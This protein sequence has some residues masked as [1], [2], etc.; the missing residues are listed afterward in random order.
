MK[1]L[2]YLFSFFF[3]ISLTCF[4]LVETNAYEIKEEVSLE[5]HDGI[6]ISHHQGEV[7]WCSLDSSIDF[8]ICKATEGETFIDS[9]FKKNWDSIECVK[10]C[11]HFFRP[12]YS[13]E[14]QALLYLSVINLLPGKYILSIDPESG[15]KVLVELFGEDLFMEW[16]NREHYI[17]FIDLLGD[18]VRDKRFIIDGLSYYI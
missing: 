8:I 4:S 6:D 15:Y 11:Y 7:E 1:Y 17:T 13:G 5:Y 12:Q 16:F 18:K 14:K 10:G 9:K 2:K 3:L